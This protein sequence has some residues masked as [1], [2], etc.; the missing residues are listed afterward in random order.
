[1][2]LTPFWA[3]Q[4]EKE[5]IYS[6]GIAIV[7]SMAEARVSALLCRFPGLCKMFQVFP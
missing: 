6:C 2:S 7:M 1:M 5:I 4:K 3:S